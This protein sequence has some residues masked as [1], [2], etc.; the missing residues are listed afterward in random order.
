[1]K[2]AFHKKHLRK[3]TGVSKTTIQTAYD[4]LMIEGYIQQDEIRLYGEP[5]NADGAVT[6]DEHEEGKRQ[7]SSCTQEELRCLIS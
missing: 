2:A 4:Q 5:Y 6:E 7:P 3:K 1:M